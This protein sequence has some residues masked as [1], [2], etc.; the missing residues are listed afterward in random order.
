MS[1]YSKQVVYCNCCG[2]KLEIELPKMMGNL[3]RCCSI[4]CIQE[5]NWR[6]TLSIMGKEYRP[7][8]KKVQ[9]EQWDIID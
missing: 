9:E 8:E 2:R 1:M 3:F 4:E 5:M 7:P 6:E